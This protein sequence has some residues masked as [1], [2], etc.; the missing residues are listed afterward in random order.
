MRTKIRPALGGKRDC[1]AIYQT[2]AVYRGGTGNQGWQTGISHGAE[3]GQPSRW[4]QANK[5]GQGVEW[6]VAGELTK[7]KDD[8]LAMKAKEKHIRLDLYLPLD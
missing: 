1:S 3:R 5:E 8:G 2:C 4:G 6:E 7:S